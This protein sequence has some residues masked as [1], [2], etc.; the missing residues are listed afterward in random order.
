[1]AVELPPETREE[2]RRSVARQS[3]ITRMLVL[4]GGD[5]YEIIDP[6]GQ[7]GDAVDYYNDSINHLLLWKM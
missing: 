1:M 6:S 2:R 3:L 4:S 5:G 7:T